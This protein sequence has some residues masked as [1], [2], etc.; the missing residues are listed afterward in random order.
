MS[1]I[2]R[3]KALLKAYG[4]D[5]V[6]L[7]ES[8]DELVSFAVNNTLDEATGVAVQFGKLSYFGGVADSK[9]YAYQ[10]PYGLF[11]VEVWAGQQPIISLV[12]HGYVPIQDLTF[13][14]LSQAVKAVASEP[15]VTR[16]RL[17]LLKI[18]R[19]N[20]VSAIERKS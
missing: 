8:S 13:A 19:D 2:G 6:E 14:E 9:R 20:N 4:L 12:R 11:I 17:Y 1:A 10:T 3:G 18:L 7:V 15:E 16:A 5:P